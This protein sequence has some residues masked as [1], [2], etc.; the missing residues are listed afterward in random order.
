MRRARHDFPFWR[1]E[2]CQKTL[3]P[4]HYFQYQC[5]SFSQHLVRSAA[6]LLLSPFA[7][8]LAARLTL[9][10]VLAA[11]GETEHASPDGSAPSSG[12]FGD[13][14]RHA[15]LGCLSK[16]RPR[17][18]RSPIDWFGSYVQRKPLLAVCVWFLV[19]VGFRVPQLCPAID[20]RR[21]PIQ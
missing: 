18:T 20:L 11:C 10:T 9:D 12:L 14:Y 19:Q 2:L 13:I 16:S 4:R 1:K 6:R 21:M 17:P 5:A 15:I 8:P 3:S 7:R